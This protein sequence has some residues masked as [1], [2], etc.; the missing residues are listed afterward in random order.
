MTRQEARLRE[1]WEPIDGLDEPLQP[2]NMQ[3]GSTGTE[4]VD[5][6]VVPLGAGKAP[7]SGKKQALDEASNGQ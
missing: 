6:S 2:L 3:A 7:G 4:S 5:P 1:D